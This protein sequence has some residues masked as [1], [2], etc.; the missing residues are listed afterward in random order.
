LLAIGA[1][2]GLLTAADTFLTAMEKSLLHIQVVREMYYVKVGVLISLYAYAFF[3]FG[4]A[5][6][7]FNYSAVMIA[8]IPEGETTPKIEKCAGKAAEMNII[9][10]KQ[11]NYGLRGFFMAIPVL[12][13]FAGA[14]AFAALTIVVFA[15]LI[16]RQFFSKALDI[17]RLNEDNTATGT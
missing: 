9:A 3:K 6:R 5:Y 17:A 1:G 7:L 4:W 14:A 10:S 15:I 8:A 13:W 2:F 11:F 12:A 16:H